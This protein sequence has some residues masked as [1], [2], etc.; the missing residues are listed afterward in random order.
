MSNMINL[1]CCLLSMPINQTITSCVF[2]DWLR[3][4]ELRRFTLI[5]SEM[6][7]PIRPSSFFAR[8]VSTKMSKYFL[9]LLYKQFPWNHHLHKIFNRNSVKVSYS[10][11]KNMKTIINNHNKNILGMT[12]SI[13]TSTCN[14]RNKEDGTLN[15]Q[16]QIG[17]VT[18][19][20]PLTKK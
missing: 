13:N 8:N 3:C 12:L 15:G 1:Q 17:E 11:T 4:S 10:C 9:N 19:E 20:S 5:S 7:L 2:F 16:W 14:C 18:C 6:V